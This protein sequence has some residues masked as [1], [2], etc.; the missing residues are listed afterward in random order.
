M[1]YRALAARAFLIRPTAQQGFVAVQDV[2]VV[3]L[4]NNEDGTPSEE[5]HAASAREQNSC[6]PKNLRVSYPA[7]SYI[8][9]IR[10]EKEAAMQGTANS[11]WIDPLSGTSTRL[12][13]TREM[14]PY[15]Q[16]EGQAYDMYASNPTYPGNSWTESNT[17][18]LAN[19]HLPPFES[20]RRRN[21]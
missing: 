20:M 14:L 11:N 9:Q 17:M 4:S 13:S 5:P 2:H 1:K 15:D 21:T 3:N 19:D 6:V 10:L 16:G 8:S 12:M 18:D 7:G